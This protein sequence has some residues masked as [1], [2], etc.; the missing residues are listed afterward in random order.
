MSKAVKAATPSLGDIVT[1][2]GPRHADEVMAL[3]RA[4]AGSPTPVSVFFTRD[5]VLLGQDGPTFVDVGGVH[6]P[7]RHRY[8][9]HQ[10]GVARADG[11]PYSSFGLMSPEDEKDHPL[12]RHIDALDNGKVEPPPA[13]WPAMSA[14]PKGDS[15]AWAVHEAN[16]ANLDG[17]PVTDCQFEER[18]LDMINLFSLVFEWDGSIKTAAGDLAEVVEHIQDQLRVWHAEAKAAKAASAARVRALLS[19]ASRGVLVL[20]QFETA[21][22]DVLAE[23]P[24]DGP[25]YV[26]FPGPGG[27]QWMLQQVAVARGSFQGRKPL[28]ETWAPSGKRLG[29]AELATVTG[30]PDAVFCHVGRFIAGAG[31]CEGALSMARLA[32]EA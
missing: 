19:T 20:A 31:S 14:E 4:V 29:Q 26:V 8:D 23:Q 22:L 10:G 17:S 27:R 16:P 30:V 12:V 6:D 15:I 1:H 9:H 2:D 21:A 7:A 24:A 18:A 13:W 32:V 25:L 3:A 11:L 28:P 5:P